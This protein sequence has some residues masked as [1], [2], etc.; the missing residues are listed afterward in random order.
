MSNQS[1]HGPQQDG[2]TVQ[3]LHRDLARKYRN[4]GSKVDAIWRKFTSKQRETAMR[5]SIWGGKVL[6]HSHDRSL[7][8]LYV[9]IPE[10]NLRDM[11]S[12]P[13]HFLNI[14][15]SRA[16]TSLYDQLYEGVNG[17]PGDREVMEKTEMRKT[18]V[19]KEAKT[20]FLEG[21]YYGHSFEPKGVS[22]LFPELPSE[23]ANLIIIPTT[24]GQLIVYRQLFLH[25]VLNPIVGE[26][27]NLGS[28][29]RTMKPP[30]KSPHE[31]LATVFTNLN[32]QPRP[33]KSSLLEVRIQAMESKAAL[34]D[35]LHLM[36]AEP[37][38]LNQ[39][40]NA[41]YWRRAELVSDDQGRILPV[42]TDRHLS[43]AFF[44][45]VTKALKTIATWDYILRLLQLLEDVTD[46]IKRGLGMQELS[47]ICHLEFRRA[48]DNFK[49]SVAPR[50][51][52]AGERFKRMTDN[53]SGQSKIV[54]KGQ[55]ADCTVSDPQLHYILR[56]CHS[57]T[58]P[59]DAIQWIQ[60]LDDHNAR[61]DDDRKRLNEADAAALGE[62]AIIVSFMYT[63]STAVSMSPLSRKPG[64][65]FS[66]RAKELDGELKNLKP[67]ADF[68]DFV[69]P[70]NNLLEPNM[71]LVLLLLS[72]NSSYKEQGR[73][74]VRST[75][76]LCK[77][78]WQAWRN[79][80]SELKPDWTKSTS[81]PRLSHCRQSLRHQAKYAWPPEGPK[82][83]HALL[84]H[85]S[86]V[87]APL[88]T[89]QVVVTGPPQQFRV[90]AA[91]SSLFTTLF[92][93][94]EA[95]GSVSWA[96]FESAMADL[97]FSVT[98]NGGSIFTFNPAASM[99][100]RPVTLH[101]PHVSDIEGYKLLIISRRLQRKYGWGSD[102]FVVT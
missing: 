45:S 22:A 57:D 49:R 52:V 30:E 50:E 37:I 43:A 46:M 69:I 21:E 2:Q 9:Y 34:E 33:L 88:E 72:T 41:A 42:I 48:Q 58:S 73:G 8:V 17:G 86:T 76:T 11:T 53:A 71:A 55:P 10:Y 25:T 27:L 79:C 93:R 83:K 81:R 18:K 75:R 3:E 66:A 39:A 13:E 68:G 61:Y 97:G 92:F 40:V 31:A 15:Q 47:N 60:K 51:S 32:V 101:R 23:R 26:I 85:P 16:S 54:M 29:T 62:L 70:M 80:M 19:S 87:T 24:L 4:V 90:K 6:K 28:E 35:H 56:L 1:T 64:L 67:K 98:P 65:M 94:T 36:R 102:S 7:G 96:S 5:R 89:P 20:V 99:N 59:S 84:G 74:W 100:S 38:V 82:R 14:F 95:R 63:T 12:K 91:T 78:L 77:T 44:D